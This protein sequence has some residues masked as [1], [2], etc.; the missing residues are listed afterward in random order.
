MT[1]AEIP[2]SVPVRL[3]EVS[4]A[5]KQVTLEANEATR[6]AL[7]RP[8]GVEAVERLT[9]TLDLMPRG[10][11]GL[12]VTG[13]VTGA[14]RQICVITLEPVVNQIDEE[15][16]VTFAPPDEAALAD[17]DKVQ[18]TLSEGPEPLVNGG[19][20]LGAL[21]TEYLILGIDPHPRKPGATFAPPP[22]EG[23]AHP[24]AGLAA[25]AKKGTVKD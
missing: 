21:A 6:A 5:G 3:D 20:D 25:L 2:W 22:V 7:A 23:V 15:V 11:D 19:V 18:G 12:H 16:D 14:V 8:A 17:E 1:V 4:D 24:F 10:R 9:A 13:R